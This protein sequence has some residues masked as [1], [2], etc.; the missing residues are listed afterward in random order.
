MRKNVKD[1]TIAYGYIIE[2]VVGERMTEELGFHNEE[3]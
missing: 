2:K 1:Q 3:C